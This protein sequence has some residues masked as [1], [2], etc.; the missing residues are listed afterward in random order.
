MA[1]WK[2]YAAALL[3]VLVLGLEAAGY[4]SADQA[5]MIEGLLGFLGLA[6]L[7]SGVARATKPAAPESPAPPG[8]RGHAVT[9]ALAALT[10][11]ALALLLSAAGCRSPE[12]EY[13]E[14]DRATYRALAP[15]VERGAE[16][17]DEEQ[18]ALIRAAI[19]S[20]AD[21]IHEAEKEGA[22]GG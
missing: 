13:V 19:E 12:R 8:E 17:L 1:G 18:R 15:V 22:A 5:R 20:W 11:A 2:T 16:G 7:R 10:I 6:A 21:R 4:L 9:G 14:A 3:G